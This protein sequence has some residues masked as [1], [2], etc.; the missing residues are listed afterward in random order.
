MK[1]ENRNKLLSRLSHSKIA[2]SAILERG[3]AA[4][5]LAGNPPKN[6]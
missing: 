1:E 4:P 2:F 3:L 6:L 5:D